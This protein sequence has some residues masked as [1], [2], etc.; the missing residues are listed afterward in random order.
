MKI[1]TG[2]IK[3]VKHEYETRIVDRIA[4]KYNGKRVLYCFYRVGGVVESSGEQGGRRSL[5][6]CRRAN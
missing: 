1:G 6:S 5:Q 3:S 4:A 2:F